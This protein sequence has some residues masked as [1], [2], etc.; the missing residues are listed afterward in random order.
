[1][2][3]Y[4]TSKYRMNSIRDIENI[5]YINLEHRTDRKK[6]VEKELES[7][8]LL[9]MTRRFNA[10]KSKEGRIGCTLSHLKCLE[11]AKEQGLSHIMIIEDDIHFLKPNIFTE[12]LNTFLSSNIKWDVILLA[13]NNLPPYVKVGESA[14]K[15]SQC[16]TTTGYIVNKHYY[17]TLISNI[18]E[19]TQMLLK[20]PTQHFY[21]AIDKF[22]IQLQKR[23]DWFLITP[24]TV[25]QRESFSDIE[26]RTTNYTRAMVDLD[27][28]EFLRRAEVMK[29]Q[30]T[31]PVMGSNGRSLNPH[32]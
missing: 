21:Y 25:T 16:Q 32:K 18:R 31:S 6:E 13:G 14:V 8:G 15:V 20:N 9:H 24:L 22:W 30:M 28:T 4:Y 23:D 2:V 17:D 29:R 1:M 19:G 27:K 5:V 3:S 26:Q 10:I 11:E 12:Q 7:I